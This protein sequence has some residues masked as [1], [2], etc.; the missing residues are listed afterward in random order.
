M[1]PSVTC[2]VIYAIAVLLLNSCTTKEPKPH[3][4]ISQITKDY[5]VFQNGSTWVMEEEQ[6]GTLDT[7]NIFDFVHNPFAE[8]NEIPYTVESFNFKQSS[9]IYVDSNAFHRYHIIK[10]GGDDINP[11][12]EVSKDV[13]NYK[14]ILLNTFFDAQD[15][16]TELSI[17]AKED[18][19]YIEYLDSFKVLNNWFKDVRVYEHRVFFYPTQ[20]AKI[21]W[22]KNIGHIRYELYN[23]EKWNLKDYEV[24]Q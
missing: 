23:G 18:F 17:L 15:T 11:L 19:Y 6:S 24:L 3:Y 1:K 9:S 5:C 7:L 20:I 22:A 13:I 12:N 8:D 4:A 21:Y 16:G 14:S 10:Y 2:T